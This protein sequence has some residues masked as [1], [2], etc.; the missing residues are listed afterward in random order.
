[1]QKLSSFIIFILIL[2]SCAGVQTN[3]DIPRKQVTNVNMKSQKDPTIRKRIMVLPFLDA[4]EDRDPKIRENARKAFV[5]DLNRT[6]QVIAIDS[7]ELKTDLSKEVK[8]GEYIMREIAKEAGQLGVNSVLEGKIM[9]LKVRRSSDQVGLI[10]QMTTQYET[11][12]RVRVVSTRGQ[13]ELMNIVKT[14]TLDDPHTRVGER[15]EKDRLAQDSA[16]LIQ[17]IIKDAFM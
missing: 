7:Q 16:E 10:R 17:I 15:V 14:V 1:M 2:S 6:G 9:E 13:R 3:R 5:M 8:N 11:V 12:V 4:R